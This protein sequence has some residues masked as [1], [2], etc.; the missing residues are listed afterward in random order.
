MASGTKICIA[1]LFLSSAAMAQKSPLKRYFESLFMPDTPIPVSCCDESD[2]RVT[3]VKNENGRWY[4][5]I[6]EVNDFVE[7]PERKIIHDKP[8]PAGSA[9]VCWLDNRVLCFVPPGGGY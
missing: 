4:A 7:I 1:F 5:Y 3:Q 6:H 2:C 8:H 9:V